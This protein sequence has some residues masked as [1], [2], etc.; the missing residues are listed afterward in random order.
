MYAPLLAGWLLLAPPAP[1]LQQDASSRSEGLARLSERVAALER[2]QD[3]A[4]TS[5]GV[6]LGDD[7]FDSVAGMQPADDVYARPWY[8]KVDISGYAAVTF[9]D[10]GSAGVHAEPGTLVREA[11]LFVDA[12][13]WEDV[14]VF[15]ELQVVRFDRDYDTGMDT[16]EVYAR[17][18]DVFG[19]E[20]GNGVDIKFG[21]VDIPFGEE[22][23]WQDATENPLINQSASFPYGFDEGVVV[24]GG[25]SLRW[26]AAIL[27]GTYTRSF[28]TDSG[29]SYALKLS[30]EPSDEVYLSAS[31]YWSGETPSAG[32][33][34]SGRPL[35]P[36]GTDDPYLA[37]GA[38]PSTAGVS[39]SGEIR[40][41]L[42]EVDLQ[43]DATE[44]TALAV[45][46]GGGKLD[47]RVN[48]FDRDLVWVTVEPLW[49][50]EDDVYLA[51]RYSDVGTNDSQEGYRFDGKPFG[52]GRA[53]GY[54][55]HRLQRISLGVGWDV[56]PSVTVKLEVAWDDFDL[57]PTSALDPGDDDRFLV[58][59]DV[60]AAF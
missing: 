57:I 31:A 58:G 34:I 14:S 4:E 47:D 42:V 48:T 53:L 37:A 36:V 21:R 17:F 54:D 12:M 7:S 28:D 51:L 50:V 39:P 5:S 20:D 41:G 19:G 9:L 23:L 38:T 8:E 40:A 35:E 30:G 59:L 32:L 45:A 24:S 1:P 3:G 13:A 60:V 16:G 56:H 15:Y 33:K 55:T 6:D 11:S 52:Y 49:R 44:R 27:D 25:D 43:W 29:K 46:V 26:T 22:Y 2:A 10:N 18:H